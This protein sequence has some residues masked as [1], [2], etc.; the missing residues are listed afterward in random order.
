MAPILPL[1]RRFVELVFT[2]V[3]AVSPS[4]GITLSS[5]VAQLYRRVCRLGSYFKGKKGHLHAALINAPSF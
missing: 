2:P 1:E 5:L 3:A 4:G